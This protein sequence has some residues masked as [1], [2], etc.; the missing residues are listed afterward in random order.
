M[1][2]VCIIDANRTPVHKTLVSL[3]ARGFCASTGD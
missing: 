3:K 1:F 2:C